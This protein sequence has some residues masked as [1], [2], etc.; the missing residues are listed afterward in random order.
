MEEDVMRK[1]IELYV[2]DF[3]FDMQENGKLA[4]LKMMESMGKKP[5]DSKQIFISETV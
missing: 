2:N 5:Y 1:H 3:S 4:I